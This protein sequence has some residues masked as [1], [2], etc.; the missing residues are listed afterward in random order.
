MQ[1]WY[2]LSEAGTERK[3]PARLP[4]EE[5]QKEPSKLT[6]RYGIL[7][8]RLPP[9]SGK[10]AECNWKKQAMLL[11]ERGSD[12]CDWR[13]INELHFTLTESRAYESH[14]ESCH[15]ITQED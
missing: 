7:H 4:G 6:R 9:R 2:Q 10:K 3:I 14:S 5:P 15:A 8:A 13:I 12:I 1:A 11:R